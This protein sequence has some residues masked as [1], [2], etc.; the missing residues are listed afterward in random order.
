MVQN[1]SKVNQESSDEGES[2]EVLIVI[3]SS[4]VDNWFLDTRATYHM[5]FSRKLFT[6]FKE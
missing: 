2:S 6:S 5:T 3:T 1:N 4:I